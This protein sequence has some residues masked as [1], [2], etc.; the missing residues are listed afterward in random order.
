MISHRRIQPGH[1]GC[2]VSA[3]R[4]GIPLPT[5]SLR[6]GTRFRRTPSGTGTHFLCLTLLSVAV[7]CGAS[8]PAPMTLVEGTE[9][10]VCGYRTQPGVSPDGRWL[11]FQDEVDGL[12]VVEMESGERR[13]PEVE[14]EAQARI[15]GGRPPDLLTLCWSADGSEAVLLGSNIPTMDPAR[16][17]LPN[18]FSL[19]L[20]DA[21]SRGSVESASSGAWLRVRESAECES[22]PGRAW[23]IWSEG[24]PVA[25][26]S[27]GQ[28]TGFP[29]R[30]APDPVVTRGSRV[31]QGAEERQARIVDAGGQTLAQVRP[32]LLAPLGGRANLTRFA[33]SPDGSRLA[34][35]SSRSRLGSWGG[36]SGLHLR[37]ADGRTRTLIP[38]DRR[39][40]EIV[41]ANDTELLACLPGEPGRVV[42]LRP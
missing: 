26:G 22:R 38:P 40:P 13:I 30:D 18:V 17:R 20:G 34:W 42:R 9:G 37:E 29:D 10:A 4:N 3:L 6:A 24:R 23:D 8:D 1:P 15:D 41:W 28:P 14:P 16:P 5:L 19:S 2:P 31:I 32:P 12:V 27:G 36:Q 7:G 21:E 11:V 35:V 25:P 33:W 39:S